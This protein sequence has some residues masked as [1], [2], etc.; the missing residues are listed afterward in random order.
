MARA[1]ASVVCRAAHRRRARVH[2]VRHD[3]AVRIS[4]RDAAEQRD[5]AAH[6]PDGPRR[7]ARGRGRLPDSHR[8]VHAACRVHS[9]GGDGRRVLPG[10]LSDELLAGREHGHA[11][12][13]LLLLLSLSLR[14]RRRDL[15][16]RFSAGPLVAVGYEGPPFPSIASSARKL[17][18]SRKIVATAS[19]LPPRSYLT[20]TS[21]LDTSPSTTVRSHFSA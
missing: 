16:R 7:P 12:H 3:E 21:C 2:P 6:V 1:R 15:E 19:V 17:S 4:R 8:T 9:L 5:G 11:G 13:P 10:T 20:V 14:R 18:S